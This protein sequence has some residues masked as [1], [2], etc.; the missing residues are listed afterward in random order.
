MCRVALRNL[1]IGRNLEE[2]DEGLRVIGPEDS[3]DATRC[4]R[5]VGYLDLDWIAEIEAAGD[6]GDRLVLEQQLV[7]GRRGTVVVASTQ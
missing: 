4:Q 3:A 6:V 7:R 1:D 2:G 5:G